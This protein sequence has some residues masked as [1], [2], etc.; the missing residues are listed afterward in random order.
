MDA[1]REFEMSIWRIVV[2]LLAAIVVINLLSGL[3]QAQ[4]AA[5]QPELADQ[6]DSLYDRGTTPANRQKFMSIFIMLVLGGGATYAVMR[7]I[8]KV[9]SMS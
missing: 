3:A 8:R 6:L 9:V 2:V 5:A 1:G 7:G 4:P